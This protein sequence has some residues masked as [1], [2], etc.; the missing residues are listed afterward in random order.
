[1]AEETISAAGKG[2][3]RGIG[4]TLR[5]RVR[6]IHEVFTA[7]HETRTFTYVDYVAA[8]YRVRESTR[9]LTE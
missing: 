2:V 1:M 5:E 6:L 9:R 7:A 4:L 3:S 8:R